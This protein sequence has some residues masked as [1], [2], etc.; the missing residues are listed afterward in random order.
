MLEGI[1]VIE[2][3][4]MVAAPAATGLLAEWGADV[5]KIEPHTGDPMRGRGGVLG[6]TNY[7]LHSRG[8]RSIALDTKSPDTRDIILRLVKDAD[9]FVTNMLPG[10]LKKRKLDWDDLRAVNPKLVY[11]NVT[12]FGRLGPDRDRPAM[13]NAGFWARAGGTMLMT[14]KGND[15]IPNR[16]SVGDRITGLSM[17]SGILAALIE[18]QRTGKGRLVEASLLRSSIWTFGTDITNAM[19]RG[20]I[21]TSKPRHGAVMPLSNFF[22]TRDDKWI[23]IHT[24]IDLAAKALDLPD[25]VNDDRFATPQLMRENGPALVDIVDAEFAKRD[26]AEW[27]DRLEEYGVIWEP[28]QTAMDV[29]EDPQAIAAGCFVDVPKPGGE[30]GTQREVA[31]PPTF[32]N[33]DGTWEDGPQ[34][35]APDIGE[36]TLEILS[37]YGYNDEDVD[38]FRASGAIV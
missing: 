33:D 14:V 1:R 23:L 5:I 13:D 18:A 26:F 24:Q 20:R 22:K 3:A 31:N 4:T 6:S 28:A 8:K 17:C 37:Q 16:Q 38:R 2:L 15:P 11:G 27:R 19:Q 32:F 34:G 7:D 25:L 29:I 10:Q 12:S 35:Y 36:H 21:A 30:P 9:I